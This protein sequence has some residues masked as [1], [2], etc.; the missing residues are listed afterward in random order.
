MNRAAHLVALGLA[1]VPAHAGDAGGLWADQKTYCGTIRDTGDQSFDRGSF[2][3]GVDAPEYMW[4]CWAGK[5]LVCKVGSTNH[6]DCG[7]A[8]FTRS[9]TPAMFEE[10]A[11][12]DDNTGPSGA[13]GA[14]SSIWNWTCRNHRPVIM[15]RS[16]FFDAF[17][18]QIGVWKGVP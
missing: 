6:V 15:S 16:Q 3:S 4:R 1:I 13:S 12:D 9:P 8:S 11:Q 2:G 14:F 18:Y 17:G 5:L 7:R 10:C